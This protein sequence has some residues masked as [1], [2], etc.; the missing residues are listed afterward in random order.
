MITNFKFQF[1]KGSIKTPVRF[2][3]NKKFALFQFHKGS[4]KT[5]LPHLFCLPHLQFQFHKGSIKTRFRRHPLWR[6]SQATSF[7]VRLRHVFGGTT[8]RRQS[9]FQFHKGSIKTKKAT[10]IT[11]SMNFISIP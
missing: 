9:L 6:P 1:H 3:Y 7:F 8:N 11:I 10:F 2:Y 4:I 5:S